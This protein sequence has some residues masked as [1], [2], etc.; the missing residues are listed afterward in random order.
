[1]MKTSIYSKIKSR[2]R[3][4]F[5]VITLFLCFITVGALLIIRSSVIASSQSLGAVSAA[6][7]K[8]DLETQAKNSLYRLTISRAESSDEQ[9]QTIEIIVRVMAERL[10]DIMSNSQYYAP[11]PIDFP[12]PLNNGTPVPQLQLPEGVSRESLEDEIG[13]L[14]NVSRLFLSIYDEFNYIFAVQLG[15]LSGVTIVVDSDSGLKSPVY[16]ARTRTWYQRAMQ[17]GALAWTDVYQ[18]Y[19][20][21]GAT[22][23]CAA[24][25]Y[26]ARGNIAGIVS[27]DIL[28]NSLRERL[29]GSQIGETGH[30]FI[31]DNVGNVI[32]AEAAVNNG[33]ED[34]VHT[35]TEHI[36]AVIDG[37]HILEEASGIFQAT[38]GDHEYFIAFAQLKTLPW[39][40]MFTIRISEVVAPAITS[41]QS[42]MALT[43]TEIS[44]LNRF[45][46]IMI[47]ILIALILLVI[48]MSTFMASRTAAVIAK[49][50]IAL[51]DGANLITSGDL[52]HRFNIK[53]GDEIENLSDSFN[54]MIDTI[55]RTTSEKEHIDAEMH[56]ANNIQETLMPNMVNALPLYDE[57]DLSAFMTSAK[58]IGGNF[59]DV[60]LVN[61]NNLA[62]VVA[63]VG[64]QGI[65]A[66]LLMFITKAMI[67]S[68]LQ[69]GIMPQ[70]VLNQVNMLLVEKNDANMP[71]Y[72][73]ISVL[74]ITSGKLTYVNAGHKPPLFNEGDGFFVLNNNPDAALALTKDTKYKQHDYFL[75]PGTQVLFFTESVY[76]LMKQD[77]VLYSNEDLIQSANALSKLSVQNFVQGLSSEF[78]TH[79]DV[80]GISEAMGV[81]I[82]KYKGLKKVTELLV[83]ANLNNIPR[84]VDF[85]T[86]NIPT[87]DEKSLRK[88][89]IV[90]DEV[91]SNIARVAYA[92]E[93]G[94]VLVRVSY[95]GELCLEFEDT[96]SPYHLNFTDD[97]TE[98]KT[99]MNLFMSN[100]LMDKIEYTRRGKRNL[101]SLT[102][103]MH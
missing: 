97:M 51:N 23:T 30:V 52:A 101:L 62:I 18:D 8:Q 67:K 70:D 78:M 86:K 9:L 6:N 41:S 39:V 27:A 21:I 77:G 48:P 87:Q 60:F 95:Q 35:I 74:D 93:N 76:H 82:I 3:Y 88:V 43:S 56:I 75:M 99:T 45:L 47:V 10:T 57:F 49:P 84:I 19:L 68:K 72:A 1:M 17:N 38:A 42:I 63:S 24:P 65:P 4:G 22:I 15:T 59:Y 11:Q 69:S 102:K 98:Q 29:V 2:I 94:N 73:F 36:H 5:L 103:L 53:T 31:L 14:A 96:G 55:K 16:D 12:D 64:G 71:M 46:I 66:A 80:H 83:E 79:T 81:C 26:D 100:K 91:I 34:D 92:P 32:I 25:F 37:H 54:T 50:I 20:G 61:E 89:D 33:M 58:K 90:V 44:Q 13:L 40:M 28:I 7:S 85:I